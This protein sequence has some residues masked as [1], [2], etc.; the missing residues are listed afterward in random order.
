MLVD[1]KQLFRSNGLK[2]A[3]LGTQ[4]LTQNLQ[5]IH[6]RNSQTIATIRKL[7]V[8]FYKE[9]QVQRGKAT[10]LKSHSQ[11]RA[12]MGVYI[13]QLVTFTPGSTSQ[14]DE[15]QAGRRN[16]SEASRAAYGV[17]ARRW[18]SPGEEPESVLEKQASPRMH[19]ALS[20]RE[21]ASL[22]VSL[23]RRW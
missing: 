16:G 9:A 18:G 3:S 22:L 17:W 19:L 7:L 8:R 14:R 20:G 11:C 15:T 5:G 1:P 2:V 13:L 4:L 23:H 12:G 6:S 10:C 21:A